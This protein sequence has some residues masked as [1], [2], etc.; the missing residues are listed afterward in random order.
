VARAKRAP[1]SRGASATDAAQ[2]CPR[3]P[4][5]L[6]RR[7]DVALAEIE[8][9]V[10]DVVGEVLEER[11]GAAADVEQLRA[12]RRPHELA[13]EAALEAPGAEQVLHALVH[14][15][16]RQHG[17]QAG[18]ALAHRPTAYTSIH[19]LPPGSVATNT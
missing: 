4:P 11:R 18:G 15:R 3:A 5:A 10:A 8:A 17:A 12:G 1:V 16:A 2:N 6:A 7:G 19:C 9:V 14:R 13:H